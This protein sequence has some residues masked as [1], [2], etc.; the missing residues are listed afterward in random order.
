MPSADFLSRL[1]TFL[2]PYRTHLEAEV[3]YLRS[4][5]AQRQRRVDELQ[6]AMVV[7]AVPPPKTPREPKPL[8]PV[9]PRGWEALRYQ[10][11]NN[12]QDET[13][14]QPSAS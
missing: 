1:R 2:F 5:L 13:P 9:Q 3:E 10:H 4:Q 7:V 8:P 12:V 14:A 11:R 6:E